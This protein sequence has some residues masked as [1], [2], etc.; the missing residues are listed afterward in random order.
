[1]AKTVNCTEEVIIVSHGEEDTGKLVALW[2]TGKF[3][4]SVIPAID[5]LQDQITK[6]IAV[7][8]E[9]DKQLQVNLDAEVTARTNVD[10]KLQANID[11]EANARIA[12]DSVL[13]EQITK[14]AAD[15]TD[16]NNVLQANIDTEAEARAVG[17]K[18][19]QEQLAKEFAIRTDSDTTLQSNIDAEVATRNA[20]NSQL[21]ISINAEADARTKADQ[22]LQDQITAEIAARTNGD[23]SESSIRASAYKDLQAQI[24]ALKKANFAPAGVVQYFA[25]QIAP[26]G[27]LKANGSAVSRSQY[28]DLFAAISTTF[29]VGDGSTTFN[30]P[31]LR[32]EF[33]RGFDDGRGV[34]TGRTLGSC[35]GEAL[36]SHN[37]LCA[38][39]NGV[40]GSY[41][42][43][44]TTG[45]YDYG[46]EA[47][48]TTSTGD[49]ETRPRNVALLA[50][51]KY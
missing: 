34:D 40:T 38:T 19:L 29:G 8:T 37:H 32:G 42:T 4:P 24:D 20:A 33:V 23:E 5:D 21:Q 22:G 47:P 49:T 31:D 51:I 28:V 1:M 16:A 14:E 39:Y 3:H 27:W 9:A 2:G 46:D 25:Q 44:Y 50:C 12:A 26:E 11:S 35:Q 45:G 18:D 17:D 41:E 15:R 36:K 13:Q 7:R 6:E 43:A 30:L 48:P 10:A